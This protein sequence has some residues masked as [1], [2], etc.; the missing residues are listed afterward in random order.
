MKCDK[1]L[2]ATSINRWDISG[3][4]HS[5]IRFT[6]AITV[7]LTNVFGV[8]VVTKK[9]YIKLLIAGTKNTAACS[10]LWRSSKNVKNTDG[11]LWING[12]NY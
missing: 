6:V 7:K 1:I 10:A 3:D 5:E 4:N 12:S 9:N 2:K 11:Y 8:L